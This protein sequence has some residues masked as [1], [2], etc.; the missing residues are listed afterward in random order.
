MVNHNIQYRRFIED[1]KVTNSVKLSRAKFYLVTEYIDVNGD[2]NRYSDLEAPIIFT[3]YV[4]RTKDIIHAVKLSN[5][6]PQKIK[7]FF[8]KFVNEEEKQ[9]EMVGDAR[10]IYSKYVSKVN[11]IKED[12]YR[13]YKLSGIKKIF[14]L[15]MDETKLTPKNKVATKVDKKSEK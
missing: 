14:E 3:L 11:F 15:D 4:S 9:I 10:N 13:T 8:G 2:T 7:K 12:A 6:S 1:K 5:I